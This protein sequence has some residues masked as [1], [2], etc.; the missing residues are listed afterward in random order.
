MLCAIAAPVFTDL[1]IY[2]IGRALPRGR[3]ARLA[4]RYLGP[5]TRVVVRRRVRDVTIVR[6]SGAAPFPTVAVVAGAAGVP[7]WRFLA[8]SILAEAPC[9]AA[10]ALLVW[11]VGG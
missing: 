11:S 8:G 2:L 4:G 7:L 1:V 10:T 5:V 9:T 3:L 6:L